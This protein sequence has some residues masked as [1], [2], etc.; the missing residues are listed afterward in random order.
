M[1][2]LKTLKQYREN[3]RI[4]KREAER[5]AEEV[6]ALPY[7]ELQEKLGQHGV[8]EL[9][10]RV[11]GAELRFVIKLVLEEKNG[12]LGIDVDPHGLPT[13]FGVVEGAQCVVKKPK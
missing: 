12:E 4:L 8:F 1:S 11:G 7:Q 10:R 9:T 2:L 3:Y 5:V 6:A 13:L